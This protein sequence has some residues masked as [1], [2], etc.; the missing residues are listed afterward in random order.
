V[1]VHQIP[2]ASALVT[3]GSAVEAMRR[4]ESLNL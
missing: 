4:A 2:R 3:T 1:Q